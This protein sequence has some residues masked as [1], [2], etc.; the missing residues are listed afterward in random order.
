MEY[1]LVTATGAKG[2]ADSQKLNEAVNAKLK[3]G[4]ELYGSP[5]LHIDPKMG[6]SVYYQAM[7]KK[8]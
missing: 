8:P 2:V 4:F 5:G 1:Y 7:I 6:S 3:E